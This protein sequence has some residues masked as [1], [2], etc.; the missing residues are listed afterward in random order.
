[1]STFFVTVCL[2][3]LGVAAASCGSHTVCQ[4]CVAKS[5]CYY[6]AD[7]KSCKS[8]GLINTEKNNGTAYVHR[9]YDCPRATD[10]YD[11]DFARNTAFV[12]AAASNGDFAEIQTCLDNR[13]PGGKV[14]SQYTLVCDHI[15]SNCSGYI[16]VNDDD[17][18]IT[19]VFRGTKGTK[20]FREEEIDLILYISDSV[21]FFGGKVF[22]Y[23]H[24]SFDILWNGG[25]QK[26]LQTL[27]L[28]HPTY[29]L[30]AFGH[31]L[32]GALASLTS[33]AAVKSGY[34][35]SDKV[36]LYTFGQP[37][38][39]N[40]DFAEVHDQTIPHAFRIIHGKD[41]VPEAPVR[42]SYADTDAYHHRTA[43]LYDN[44][45]S[46]TATYTVSP[47]PDPT[48]GLKFINLNDKFNLHL[49]YFGVDIDN[50]YVQGCI[51]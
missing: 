34:F 32:G 19:V 50:L 39:G 25:I 48:Y 10:V 49:T 9:D 11:P 40:I 29:K 21:D 4:E 17:Q 13:L 26:D 5:V 23:F 31:S 18:T 8:I 3:V 43:V 44:D 7:T 20:Q 22:S 27:A 35:T 28:L 14:Y 46:P 36:T 45:M 15:K 41:I 2:A 24:Q 30:Q 37:R 38:T 47:T 16:S 6:N 12:Y 1:M 51:F 33:L 42:L